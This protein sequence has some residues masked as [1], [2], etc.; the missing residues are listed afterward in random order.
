VSDIVKECTDEKVEDKKERRRLQEVHAPT[1]STQA[2]MVKL[3]DKLYNL[4][5]MQKSQPLDWTTE[6]VSEYVQWCKRVVDGLSIGI[7]ASCFVC[8]ELKKVFKSDEL[9]QYLVVENKE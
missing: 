8:T 2:K 3:A 6:Q 7:P 9:S 5:N 1:L 4:R